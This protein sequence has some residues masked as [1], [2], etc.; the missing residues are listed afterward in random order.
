MPAALTLLDRAVA[1][2]TEQDPA[3]LELVR[4][5]SMAL[6][7]A[8]EV[9]RAEALL[10]GLIEVA[11]AT[12]DRRQEWSGLIERAAR[13]NISGVQADADELLQVSQEAIGVF[14]ELGDDAGLARAWRRVA[15]AHQMRSRFGPAEQAGERA[16]VHAR[17][18]G[19]R[20]EEARIVDSVCTSLLFGPAPAPEAIERCAQMYEWAGG[21]RVMEA[22]IGISL[23]GLKAMRGEFDEARALAGA[24]R[25]TYDELGLRL[26]VAGLTQVSGPLEALAG[27]LDAAERELRQGMEILKTVGSTAYQ[28]ALLA[29]VL[30]QRDCHEEADALVAITE[31]EAA[32]DNIAAQVTWR[33]VRAKLS[34][35]AELAREGVAIAD[36]TDDLNLRAAALANLAE[37]L[38]LTDAPD[39][40]AE[41]LRRAVELY[42]QKGNVVAS[43]RASSLLSAAVR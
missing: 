2:L 7:W 13:K 33:G 35:V 3:T 41:A 10:N 30:Y 19:D 40:G 29:E 5:L 15:Y 20:H 36:R 28:A 12:G 6:W 38:R 14:E 8:G 26:A 24:A 37:V 31:A 34:R 16:L 42:E 27:D 18:A 25:K 32:A 17:R 11:A 4:E 1:L 21:S 22:N 39:D 9:A 43:S 23:A